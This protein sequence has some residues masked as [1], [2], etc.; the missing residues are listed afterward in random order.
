MC[1]VQCN[2]N[3]IVQ[4]DASGVK[5][6]VCNDG[7]NGEFCQYSNSITCNGIV[8]NDGT[9]ACNSP[10]SGI[11]CKAC[12]SGH[13]YCKYN[14]YSACESNRM[15]GVNRTT[16]IPYGSVICGGRSSDYVCLCNSTTGNKAGVYSTSC[17]PS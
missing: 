9:C 1:N 2:G 13:T 10:F 11:N 4:T 7:Y 15:C 16:G 5:K 8:R 14:T 6:C 3:G 12:D 17:I